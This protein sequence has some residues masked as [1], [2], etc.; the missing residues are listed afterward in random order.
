M[1]FFEAPS[2]TTSNLDSSCG[3]SCY[4]DYVTFMPIA[5]QPIPCNTFLT[6]PHQ[7]MITNDFT[8]RLHVAPPNL[9]ATC[10]DVAKITVYNDVNNVQGTEQIVDMSGLTEISLINNTVIGFSSYV[11]QMVTNRHGSIIDEDGITAHGHFMHYV[12]S[13]QEWVTGK[14]QFYTLAKDC[15]LEFYADI[16]GSDPDSIQLDGHP[17]SS[18]KFDKN[19]LPIFGNKYSQFIVKIK[20]HGLHTLVNNGNYV[21]YV[22]CKNVGGPNDA[23]GYLTGFNKRK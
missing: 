13:V 15:I 8:T 1:L 11:G 9:P 5:S 14:T 23:A 18:L 4:G 3:A 2:T 6:P 21:A 10:N 20:G 22:I 16:N 17:L 12:P 7:R 19:P